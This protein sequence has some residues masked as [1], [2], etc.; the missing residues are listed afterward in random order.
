MAYERTFTFE[1]YIENPARAWPGDGILGRTN[2]RHPGRRN[3]ERF[4]STFELSNRPGQTDVRSRAMKLKIRSRIR[5]FFSCWPGFARKFPPLRKKSRDELS[6]FRDDFSS[7]RETG[8]EVLTTKVTVLPRTAYSELDAIR[9][10]FM[11]AVQ[12]CR[13]GR[14]F[15]KPWHSYGPM[16]NLAAGSGTAG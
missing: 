5:S 14:S 2:Q 7:R 16:D 1:C 10:L 13:S 3:T 9:R 4:E 6:T 15:S 12:T 11:R 8:T